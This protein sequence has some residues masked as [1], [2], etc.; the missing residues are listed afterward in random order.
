LDN[1]SGPGGENGTDPSTWAGPGVLGVTSSGYAPAVSGI[2][3]NN[4][5]QSGPGVYGESSGTG[6]GVY[7]VNRGLLNQ[8]SMLKL[9]VRPL[10][11]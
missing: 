11:Q 10:Q 1:A 4:E 6:P 7:G 5:S 9:M 8:E 2:S 3:K